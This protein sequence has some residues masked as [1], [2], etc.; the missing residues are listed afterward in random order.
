MPGSAAAMAYSFGLQELLH[1]GCT[2]I[3]WDETCYE[4]YYNKLIKDGLVYVCTLDTIEDL[5][6]KLV[7]NTIQTE[8]KAVKSMKFAE[9]FLNKDVITAYWYLVLTEYAKLYQDEGVGY[10]QLAAKNT[11]NRNF[12]EYFQY[13]VAYFLLL[14]K[15]KKGFL[16]LTQL[17]IY[18]NTLSRKRKGR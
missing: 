17:V 2:V 11:N 1:W 3:F 10:N 14:I 4:W 6:H 12:F 5:S 9:T 18:I 15:F 7:K 8:N 16:K 13:K